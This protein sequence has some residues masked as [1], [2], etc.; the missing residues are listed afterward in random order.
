MMI[1]DEQNTLLQ[2][3]KARAEAGGGP[4]RLKRQ[5]EKGKMSA[6]ERIASLSDEGS[7]LESQ[8]FVTCRSTS[9]GMDAHRLPGD[10]VVTGSA[11]IDGREIWL[12][13]QDFTVLGGSLGEMHAMRI[14]QAQESAL[15]MRRPFI[16]INDSGGARIQEGI[17]SLDGYGKIFRNNILSSGVIPQISLI[18]GPCAGGAAYSPALTDFVFMVEGISQMYITGPDVIRTVTGEQ[19]THDQLG[20]ASTHAAKSGNIH[21]ACASEKECIEKVKQLLGYLPSNSSEQPPFVRD[22]KDRKPRKSGRIA[23]I[24]P[25]RITKPYNMIDIIQDVVDASS[26]L[27]VQSEWAK[28]IV[29]GFARIGGRSVGIVANQPNHMSGTLDINSSDKGARFIRTCDAFNVPI[30][31]FVDIPGYMP[32]TLQEY[33]GIIR[34]GAKM[35]Y[36]IGD[37]TV[38]KVSVIV[39]KAYGGAYIAM[40]SKSLGYDRVV[41]LSGASIA[42]MGAD[43]AAEIIYRKEIASAVDPTKLKREKIEAFQREEMNPYAA[44]A[45]G[46][47]DDVIDPSQLRNSLIRTFE[48][49]EGKKEERVQRS[50]GNIPL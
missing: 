48:S 1:A 49:L 36:A 4:E 15:K 45:T 31:T 12:S 5:K 17:Y 32:G 50:H 22:G 42:V 44:A 11:T 28:S 27:E 41:A 18:F 9:F 35:L 19:V 21:F 29:T 16:Q 30:L 26:F 3:M 2:T 6:R 7:F 25:E 10:G 34:H 46:L 20:G 13:S 14:V 40:A 23:S 37:A 38:P 8:K 24:I 47:V 33:G 39:R 43:G